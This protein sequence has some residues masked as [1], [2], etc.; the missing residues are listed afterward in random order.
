MRLTALRFPLIVGVV[1]IHAYATTVALQGGKT[2]GAEHVSFLVTF[3][4]NLISQGVARLSVPLFFL[5]AGFLF[6]QGY[7]GSLSKYGTKLHR[8]VRTLLI[9]FLFWNLLTFVAYAVGQAIPRTRV[10]F[11]TKY[12]PPIRSFGPLD[13]ANALL[14]L[15]TKYTICYQFWFIRDLI[16]LVLA[17]PAIYFL[18]RNRKIGAFFVLTL[19]AIWMSGRW[20][21]LWP[22]DESLLFFS[23]GSYLAIQ[24]FDVCLLDKRRIIFGICFG[25]LLFVDAWM[26]DITYIR[27]CMILA[28]LPFVWWLSDVAVRATSVRRS[29]V[30]LS[31]ASFF[32]FAAHEPPLSTARK[33]VFSYLRPQS[34][35]AE[36]ALYILIP[37]I[38]ICSLVMI[39]VALN[40]LTPS[41]LSLITGADRK[42]QTTVPAEGHT[43]ESSR[44]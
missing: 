42:Q 33:L 13:Y 27:K 2:A 12:W 25:T 16:V 28:G 15:T 37:S 14:G 18:C 41:F 23:F 36:L 10:Y 17:A 26:G 21:L 43:L 29:L 24:S 19:C 32:V 8:R 9:P 38:L 40:H 22:A 11:A 1:F 34:S 20:P 44:S 35:G 6:F 30:F 3:I 4:R 31:G 5:I 39:W 7:D